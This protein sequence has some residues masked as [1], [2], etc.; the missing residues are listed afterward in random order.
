MDLKTGAARLYFDAR[1][2]TPSDKPPPTIVPVGLHYD[3]KRAF[4]SSALVTFH[5]PMV[6]AFELAA[7]IEPDEPE[8]RSRERARS[9]T[10]A[11]ERELR[12]VVRA[13]ESWDLHHLMHRARKLVRAERA[14]RLGAD[15][16]RPLM[17]ERVLGFARVWAGYYARLE[18]HPAEVAELRARL[19]RYHETLRALAMEDHEL[20]QDPRWVSPWLGVLLLL[21]VATVYLVLPPILIVG[22]LVNLPVALFLLF[23]SKLVSRAYKD[24][25]TVKLL[26]GALLFP[27]SWIAAGYGTTRLHA[28]LHPMLPGLPDT[29]VLA[30]VL[31]VVLAIVGGAAALRYLRVA[32]ETARAVRVRLFRRWRRREIEHLRK[33]RSELFDAIIGLGEGLTL[34]GGVDSDGRVV[35]TS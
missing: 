13:T 17:Q 14:H 12:E 8:E 25:A 27:L 18:S 7:S 21:Q 20:D 33:E 30:G 31:V 9:L 2:A 23:L 4:R 19:E 6:I 15:P 11:I 28:V 34:P 35:S 3:D 5:P 16:G 10:L 29:P 32:R 22:Y 24:E 1:S 26:V